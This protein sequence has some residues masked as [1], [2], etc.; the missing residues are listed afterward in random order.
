V[1]TANN[2]SAQE[3]PLSPGQ[4]INL[5]IAGVPGE[6]IQKISKI[7]TVSDSGHLNLPYV[8]DVLVTGLSRSKLEKK[9]E[10]I[11]KSEQIYTNPTISIVVDAGDTTSRFV[12]VTG[13]VNRGGSM[14]FRPGMG[15]SGGVQ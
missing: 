7:Y 11:Y 10:Q 4:K 2:L 12:T 1:L 5:S 14:P 13:E 6:E 9:I 8:E 15:R 3:S